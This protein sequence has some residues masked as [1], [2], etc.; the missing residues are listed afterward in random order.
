MAYTES[1]FQAVGVPSS[2]AALIANVL[3]SADARGIRSHG[4]AR[5]PYFM[6]R[7]RKGTMQPDAEMTYREGSATTGLL[8]AGDGIGIVAAGR[9]MGRVLAMAATYGCGFVAVAN[10]SHFGYAG[11]WARQA[12]EQG[13][14]GISMSS[15]GARTAPTF[16]A[17]GLLGTNPLSVTLPGG[18]RGTGFT[19]DMATSAVAVG[20]IETAL[21][22]GR[23]VPADWVLDT[24][25][26]PALDDRGVLGY[27][28]PLLPLGGAG[29]ER[30][31]HKGYALNLMVEL[32]CGALTGTPLAD[33]IA[34]ADGS[35]AA[36]MGHFFGA[37]RID[38]F[39]AP[40]AVQEEMERT[41]E[42][43]RSSRKLPGRDRIFIP[44]EPEL[45]AEAEQ[46]A[47]GIPVTPPVLAQ[48]R[49]IDAELELGFDL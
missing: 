32:L 33:R 14:L 16:G 7:L 1:A 2:D 45:I 35:A 11:Y 47:L 28:T 31:G 4:V 42:V 21:R 41:Y 34:G 43:I 49:R 9:A 20:K 5:I 23:P 8:D 38:G 22:E 30:G 13:C 25:H 12:A 40:A 26:A 39:R 10:S 29:D 15:S 17:E 44:G 19:L 27:E 18:E 36:A 37:I 6:V 3:T 48:L 24:L 46:R